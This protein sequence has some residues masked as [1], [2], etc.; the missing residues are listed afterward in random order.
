MILECLLC[1]WY[2]A[3][4]RAGVPTR[5]IIPNSAA[6]DNCE[7]VSS[8]RN[9]GRHFCLR[10]FR[11]STCGFDVRKSRIEDRHALALSTFPAAQVRIAHPLRR[12]HVEDALMQLEGLSQ[13]L[14]SEYGSPRFFRTDLIRE[15]CVSNLYVVIVACSPSRH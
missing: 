2:H 7:T 11:K 3:V 9:R 12:C 5:V 6:E 15:E 10:H 8:V 1:S 4:C 14:R 13:H